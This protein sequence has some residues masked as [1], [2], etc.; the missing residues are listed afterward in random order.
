MLRLT[1]FISRPA[2]PDSLTPAR[3]ITYAPHQKPLE[4]WA[5]DA[6]RRRAGEGMALDGIRFYNSKNCQHKTIIRR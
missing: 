3:Y 6:D 2:R 4:L 5:R 1:R